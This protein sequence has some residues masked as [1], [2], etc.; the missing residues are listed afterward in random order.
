ML[1]LTGVH[2]PKSGFQFDGNERSGKNIP[3]MVDISDGLCKL[4][5]N[6]AM[7][8]KIKEKKKSRMLKM[9]GAWTRELE[10]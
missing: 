1:T 10:N 6:R 8:M 4:Y 5:N 7:Y 3:R 9:C 2:L